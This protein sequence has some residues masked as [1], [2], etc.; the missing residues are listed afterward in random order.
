MR[1]GIKILAMVLSVIILLS[2]FLPIS[3]TLVLN[4]ESVQNRVVRRASEFASEYLG[5]KV[6]IDR[7]D[8]DLFSTVRVEGFYVEDY[9]QDTL[10]Y[11]SRASATIRS[12]NIP[13]TGLRLGRATVEDGFFDLREMQDGELNIRPLVQRL[14]RPGVKSKFKMVIDEI[15]ASGVEFRY[16]R[17]E[18]RNPE[19]GIDYYDMRIG[20]AVARVKDFTVD[21]GR[22]WGDVVSLT[23]KE[24][25]GFVIDNL[26]T[27]FL[28]DMG[29]IDFKEFRAE[30]ATS[31]I[32]VPEMSLLGQNWDQY[33]NYIDE[34]RMEGRV[35]NSSL[36]TEDLGY[37]AP[38]VKDW[39]LVVRDASATFEG[40]V[41]NFQGDLL[42]ATIAESTTVKGT[43][44]IKGM[45]DWRNAHYTIGVADLHT[46]SSDIDTMLAGVLKEPLP[47]RVYDIIER[48]DWA[49]ARLTFG[50]RF[51]AFRTVGN[52]ETGAGAVSADVRISKNRD[53]RYDI[54]GTVKSDRLDIG[55]LLTIKGLSGISSEIMMNGSVGTQETG[56]VVGDLSFG[57]SD[58]G[59]NGY[60][61]SAIEG[62]GNINQGHYY[63]EVASQDE[64][65]EFD[66]F[67]D[68]N[69]DLPRP[70][71]AFSLSLERANLNALGINRRDSVSV[72]SANIGVEL[73]GTGVNDVDGYLSVADIVY[74][75]PAGEL[76]SDILKMEVEGGTAQK[77][78]MIE[79]DFFNLDYHSHS[80]FSEVYDYLYNSLVTYVPLLYD[81]NTSYVVGDSSVNSPT[82]YTALTIEAG[83]DINELLDAIVGGLIIAPN[84]ELGLVF[85]PK[86]NNITLRGSSEALEYSGVIFANAEWNVNNNSRDS[87]SMRVKSDG[88]YLGSRPI[89]PHLS[90]VG[91]ARENRVSVTAGFR[92]PEQNNS[93]MLGVSAQF[94][95][96]PNSRRRSVHIDI[97]PSHFTNGTQQWMLYSKG[98]DIDSTRISVRELHIAR[99]DQQLIVDGIASRQRA[100]SIRLLLNNFDISPLSAILSK[101]GYNIA[102]VSNGYATV[103]AAMG[104]PE[105][106]AAI[107]VD[108]LSVN[109]I[110][111][112]P[113][114]ITS[115]W[116][117]EANRARVII[118]NRETRDTSIRGYY[119]PQGN[120]YYARAK[121]PN[122]KLALISPFLKGIISDVEG[123]AE[124]EAQVIGN[125][126]HATLSGSGLVDNIGVT[127]DYLNVRY[128]APKAKVDII[129]N[130]IVANKVPVFDLEGNR[131]AFTMDIDLNHLSN[132]IYSFDIEAKEMLV[133]N[134]TAKD[135]DLF[136]GHVYAS[137][138]GSFK[139]DKLG[140]KMD[141][142]GTS[143]DNSTF[144]MP[145][146]GKADVAYADFV[147]FTES[148]EVAPDTTAFLTRR[149]MAYERKR[150]NMSASDGMMDI[151]MTLN[152]L[153][154]I[155]MQ[156]VI[157]PTV[158]DI[159]KGKGSGQLTMHI[160]P[161]AN[162]F[163][164]RGDVRI[165]EGTYLFTLQNILNKLFTVVPVSSIHWDGDPLGA[166][167]NIDAVYSTKASLRPLIGSS[168]QGIDTS[169]AVPVD[170]YIKLTDELMS[171][172]VTFDVQVPNVAPE[173]QTVIQSTLNDQQAIATQMFWLLAANSFSAEDTGTMG[174]SLSATTG[175]ELLSNQLSNWL[176]GD[177]YNIVLRYRPRTEITGDEVDFGFSKSWLNNR[178]I[179][180]LEGGYLSDASQQATE[181]A[182]NFVGEA[183]ITWLID[184]EGTFRF[185]GFTQTI[186]RYGENQGMQ[187]SGIGVYYN[188]SFNTFKELGQSL[189]Y[190]FSPRDSLGRVVNRREQRQMRRAARND[191]KRG[192]VDTISL[193][194]SLVVKQEEEDIDEEI[195]EEEIIE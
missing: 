97:T 15:E 195:I 9:E 19:Y 89:M 98:I 78:V 121:M 123:D 189:K 75:Y 41:S 72:L 101:W 186:D 131:G 18:H 192:A 33:K 10:I 46:T 154:N 11:V 95:S 14:Q 42:K 5:A 93:A 6:S 113:Q 130:H 66:L 177:N 133:L 178:L 182:S 152:V 146:S 62:R 59:F 126:R 171:P 165:S 22:V 70:E 128:V 127:V 76:T 125:G 1:K 65:L 149:M 194:D 114:E 99:P 104:N 110:A 74:E 161:K 188:E 61:F 181:K 90:I 40:V 172:M 68:I 54:S 52:I 30:T 43:Y 145:L 191:Q 96:V 100:D 170:C 28:V 105:I 80:T 147:K 50:G 69:L 3:L 108:A 156:L 25:S 81:N 184:P 115:N 35:E 24:R 17:L 159:I 79:S 136:Y 38:G 111:I 151:D 103:K 4:I 155:E 163:E 142:E 36:S 164:M 91:G 185:K 176:S 34:I 20:E 49:N 180:E 27:Y 135:N 183:F 137:G 60:N 82:D 175:F 157:D 8:I 29:V 7:I 102:G 117:F 187:E 119:Q 77:S 47:E 112:E 87:L 12:L 141:V 166:I 31:S 45:P 174:A 32:Y 139:G 85:N 144:Y 190:R 26:A 118:R 167:L 48:M 83:E 153:P 71:G 64:N 39:G 109:D 13:K 16:E 169:R 92:Q 63:A 150:R 120:R 84:T 51:D 134:T 44:H 158:G 106:E 116:D 162:V 55:E 140:I 67:A 173:I 86:S 148:A 107:T 23:A 21:K 193:Q 124:V 2:I 138:A 179:V 57:V 88:V 168:V 132:I 129:D 160:V 94:K 37:F 53:S 73:Q 143:A 56:G 58:L 122:V